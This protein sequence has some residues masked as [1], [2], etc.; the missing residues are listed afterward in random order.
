[1]RCGTHS[2][3]RGAHRRVPNMRP[4]KKSALKRSL[5]FKAK[6]CSKPL[7]SSGPLKMQTSPE[8][9]WKTHPQLL[10][11][12]GSPV[13]DSQTFLDFLR[14]SRQE[15]EFM[16]Q[17]FLSTLVLRAQTFR[18]HLQVYPLGFLAQIFASR[19]ISV[20]SLIFCTFLCVPGTGSILLLIL[21]I[22]STFCFL[23]ALFWTFCFVW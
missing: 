12:Q 14:L 9:A 13:P 8:M 22:P 4:E 19:I 7:E 6:P 18:I 20:T 2:E 15:P 1:M 16:R 10:P 11:G 3:G 17:A 21:K 5:G 23:V